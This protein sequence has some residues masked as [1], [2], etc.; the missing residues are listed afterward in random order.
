MAGRAKGTPNRSSGMLLHKLTKEHK[1]NFIGKFIRMFDA[2]YAVYESLVS[3]MENNIAHDM[4]PTF[5]FLPEDIELYKHLNT[6]LG[7]RLMALFAYCYPK[8]KAIEIDQGSGNKM[9]ISVNIP[10]GGDQAA[11]Q[12]RIPVTGGGTANTVIDIPV[13]GDTLTLD[14]EKL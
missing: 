14:A 8:L 7:G 5:M 2:D 4:S 6:Q 10:A 12:Y 1:F 9:S 11:P 3:K 13:N